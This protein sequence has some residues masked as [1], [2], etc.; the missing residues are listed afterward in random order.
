MKRPEQMKLLGVYNEIWKTEVFPTEWTEATVIPILKPGKDP[1][2]LT[3]CLC[4][5]MEKIVNRRFQYTIESRRLVPE[6]QFGFK[7]N[8]STI[9]VLITLENFIM[10]AIR[11]K[12]YKA[13][14]E[15]RSTLQTQAVENRWQNT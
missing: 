3:S 6:T 11:K 14:F 7:R 10:D 5:V 4:M 9:D 15:I 1:N 8:K 2:K 12:E 13:L